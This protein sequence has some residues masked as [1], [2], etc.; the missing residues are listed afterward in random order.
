[1]AR[2]IVVTGA[3]GQI[4]YSLIF[5]LCKGE[6]FAEPISLALLDLPQVQGVLQGVAMEIQDCAFPLVKGVSLHDDPFSAME[7]ADVAFL[8]G[9]KPRG[10]GMERKDLLGDNGKIFVEQGK[11]LEKGASRD[12]RVIVVGNPCNTNALILSAH[13]PRI[14]KRQIHAMLRLDHHRAKA[15]LAKKGGVDLG[16]VTHVSV[17][18][19]HSA[20]QVPDPFHARIL[21]KPAEEVL[22]DRPWMEK[23]FLE[24]VQKRGAAVIQARGKSSAASA[25]HAALC[26]MHSVL[27][28]DPDW[29]SMG[30][31]S[32][33]N[34]YG[35]DEELFFSF[36]CQV[37]KGGDWS[38][39]EGL[40]WNPFLREK[41]RITEKELIEERDLV[42]HLL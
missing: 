23:E 28:G 33:G 26:S 35:I 29:V 5:S 10:P 12:V 32:K 8:V 36:P 24:T 3:A 18:G 30:V 34:R 14:P 41:I 7:G 37:K 21:G 40:E 25:A 31:F 39:V 11:A 4:A 42:R 17:W 16:K 1:M 19:N 38:I 6:L 2:R 27:H 9:S 22:Q 20:T 13:A 15:L